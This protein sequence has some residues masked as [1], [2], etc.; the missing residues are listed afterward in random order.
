MPA[1]GGSFFVCVCVA[2]THRSSHLVLCIVLGGIGRAGEHGQQG[3]GLYLSGSSSATV[4]SSTISGNTAVSMR[5]VRDHRNSILGRS[6]S[7][8]VLLGLTVGRI[9]FCVLFWVGSRPG[10]GWV[11]VDVL[12]GSESISAWGSRVTP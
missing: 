11:L 12:A 3:G 10:P 4:T 6:C 2:G 5:A 9:W 7:V 1:S 8:F